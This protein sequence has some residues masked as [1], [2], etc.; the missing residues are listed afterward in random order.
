MEL[1]APMVIRKQFRLDE[2]FEDTS[3]SSGDDNIDPEFLQ[4]QARWIRDDLDPRISQE[5]PEWLKS[6]QV[7]S[8]FKF[9]EQLR[10]SRIAIEHVRYSRIHLA[11]AL[12]AGQATRWPSS[13]IDVADKLLENW[14]TRYGEI[15]EIGTLLYEDGGRL[16]GICL[17]TDLSKEVLEVKWS[18][19][20]NS[21]TKPP[22]S[23][24][25]GDLGVFKPGDWYINTMFAY[26]AR[27]ID[28]GNPLGRIISDKSGAYAV[29]LNE[30][31][32]S[33][34]PRPEVF[35]YKAKASEPG[36]FKLT[37]ATPGSRQPIRILRSHSLRSFWAPK[38][39]LRYDGL[40]KVSGWSIKQDFQTKAWT[41]NIQFERLPSQVPMTE[42][43]RHPLAEEVDDY[44][45]YK[46]IR[47][48]TRLSQN[49]LYRA[50]ALKDLALRP[51]SSTSTGAGHGIHR[52]NA[53]A[54]T[55][56]D[57]LAPPQV[58][59]SKSVP[60]SRL[61]I[62]LPTPPIVPDA[63]VVISPEAQFGEALTIPSPTKAPR[64]PLREM[65]KVVLPMSGNSGNRRLSPSKIDK[66]KEAVVVQEDYFTLGVMP[67][68]G[69]E[70]A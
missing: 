42:V 48:I 40:Y 24:R 55:F 43:L 16:F 5:G 2:L 68:E 64:T 9:L 38:A 13:V 51:I 69:Q 8:I 47:Q 35:T 17:P 59:K 70:Q 66:G 12:I 25:H 22:F 37:A 57:R 34:S 18:K 50:P 23:R 39:G 20:N 14:S 33:D 7:V 30:L 31:D 1:S 46:R 41:Y 15:S 52:P 62:E 3:E 19:A 4:R 28:S 54:I 67:V 60:R 27:I 44:T 10:R 65:L 36:R 56:A 49:A 6:D 45:E 61:R 21:K 29:I 26:H 32:E 58:A 11:A 63:A 53:P